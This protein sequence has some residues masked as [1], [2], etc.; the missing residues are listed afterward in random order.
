MDDPSHSTRP[1]KPSRPYSAEPD[2]LVHETHNHEQAGALMA[3]EYGSTD[4]ISV[5]TGESMEILQEP[6]GQ[7]AGVRVL[8]PTR[9]QCPGR[10]TSPALGPRYR[11]PEN[12]S[13]HNHFANGEK[14]SSDTAVEDEAENLMRKDVEENRCDDE[15]NLVRK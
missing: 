3:N 15:R 1:Y 9:E 5:A 4:R 11:R 6:D 2:P 12:L 10:C 14:V 13:A 7:G 8:T